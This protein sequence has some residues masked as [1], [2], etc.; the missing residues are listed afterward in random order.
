MIGKVYWY[1]G[2]LKHPITVKTVAKA[3]ITNIFKLHSLPTVIVTDRDRIF[4]SHLWQDLFKAL[5]IKLHMSTS[6]HPQTDGQTERV[7]QCLETYL[8]CMAFAQPK[9]WCSWLPMAEWWYNTSFHTSLKMTPFQALYGF[10]P[11]Q[12]AEMFLVDDN[13][14]TA[15]AMLQNREQANQIIKE[16]L[17]QAQDRMVHFANRNRS[18]RELEVGDM[19]YLKVQPYR[20]SS[21]SIH[22]FLKLHSRFYGPFRVLAK[23]GQT[24]YK[25]LLPEG[26]KL[27]HTFHVSQLKK[28][29]GP[30]AIPAP[31][32]PLVDDQGNIQLGPEAVLQRKLIPR[33]Q[34]NISI[35]VV[36]W[37]VKWLNLPK[38]SAT[39]EDASFI[40]KAFPEF[41]P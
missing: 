37:L 26:C 11:P 25:I 24:A 31:A 18:D 41:T 21:L 28:H 36:Q 1:K 33:K 6:Y 16:N 20:H 40:Q 2:L 22:R 7:N 14:E 8:R 5:G 13:V 9:K 15:N 32:L 30:L 10:P 19:V 27:H 35:P 12:V 39:W 4:T 23:V 29:R 38:V 3:F 34:G 17:Q